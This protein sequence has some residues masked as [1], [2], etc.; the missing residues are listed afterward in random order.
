MERAGELLLPLLSEKGAGQEFRRAKNRI[1]T[2]RTIVT[3]KALI[4]SVHKRLKRGGMTLF[5]FNEAFLNHCVAATLRFQ[6]LSAFFTILTSLLLALN[7][8]PHAQYLSHTP[9]LSNCPT[10][11]M[12][13]LPFQDFRNAA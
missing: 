4:R 3:T 13:R 8:P 2:A 9:C 6:L 11:K 1:N 7:F 10:R 5:H 12:R